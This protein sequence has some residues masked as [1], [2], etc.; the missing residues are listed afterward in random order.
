M[1]ISFKNKALRSDA[2]RASGSAFPQKPMSEICAWQRSPRRRLT[3]GGG[4]RGPFI[5]SPKV[6]EF[7]IMVAISTFT[8]QET[9]QPCCAPQAKPS[10]NSYCP[11]TVP[12]WQQEITVRDS[13]CFRLND[14]Q[15]P[16]NSSQDTKVLMPTAADPFVLTC[17]VLH[18][19]TTSVV[20]VVR[21]CWLRC[22]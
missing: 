10:S 7:L 15:K 3:S 13:S 5:K 21:G 16:G 9:R 18:S 4:W 1:Q 12:W 17:S 20:L 19:N 8:A 6:L 22:R 2:A 11:N 14:L